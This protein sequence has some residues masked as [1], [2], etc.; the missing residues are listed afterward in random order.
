MGMWMPRWRGKSSPEV[1]AALSRVRIF[2]TLRPRDLEKLASRCLLRHYDTG[3]T[4]LK[5]G[6]IGL[7]LFIITS[8]RVEVFKTHDGR[9]IHLAVLGAGQVLG[10]MA[11]LD[12]QPRSAS[13]A[14]LEVT[15]CLLLSRDRFRTLLK[16]RPRIAWPIVPTLAR[17]VRDLQA[18]VLERAPESP[19]PSAGDTSAATT[20][21]AAEPERGVVT[22]ATELE[23]GAAPPTGF[24]D[25]DAG[26]SPG[27]G[28]SGPDVLRVPY[29]LMMTGAVGFGESMRVCE[30]FFR[31]LDE[32]S[33]L[34]GGRPMGDVLR[35][36]PASF[37]TAGN[38]SW[39]L[40]RRLPSKL[41]ETFRDH[42]RSDWRDEE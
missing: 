38:N 20:T 26:D 19:G 39:D 37:A 34:A 29:A 36:L 18:Q 23:D 8:G 30:I 3:E 41:L 33:G 25:F 28:T 11:L 6:S 21:P 17:R 13:A 35:E 31:S 14:A 7:G 4:I 15:D 12:D 42:L 10:E 1:E 40:S 24:D 27:D 9:R 16:R 32:E 2:S 22:P 5:E